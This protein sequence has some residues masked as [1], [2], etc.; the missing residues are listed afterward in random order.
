MG[1]GGGPGIW[2][3][4]LP[5]GLWGRVMSEEGRHDAGV[6][7][8]VLLGHAV[9]GDVYLELHWVGNKLCRGNGGQLAA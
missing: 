6:R 7:D 2:Q 4:Q 9:G 5:L 1:G 8:R 3:G